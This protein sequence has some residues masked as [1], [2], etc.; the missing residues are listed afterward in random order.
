MSNNNSPHPPVKI[1][2]EEFVTVKSLYDLYK[3]HYEQAS[4]WDGI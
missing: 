2:E 4:G 3:E 1:T